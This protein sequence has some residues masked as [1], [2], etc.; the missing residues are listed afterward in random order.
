MKTNE[1]KKSADETLKD[2]AKAVAEAPEKKTFL[3]A[4][5]DEEA[6]EALEKEL[7]GE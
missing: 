4:K 6:L 7:Q 2:M 5:T 1:V 3:D